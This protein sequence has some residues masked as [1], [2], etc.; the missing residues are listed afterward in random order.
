MSGKWH[1]KPCPVC[2]EGVLRDGHKT[3]VTEYRG[4]EFTSRQSGAYCDKCNDGITYHDQAVEDAWEQF[5][6]RVH[7]DERRELAT[8]R[9][10]LGLTQHDAARI[11]GGGHN[12]FSRYERGEAQPVLGVV[13]LFRLLGRY[14]QLL[15][16]LGVQPRKAIWTCTF[17]IP[18]GVVP[19]VPSAV[20]GGVVPL[21]PSTVVGSYVGIVA[22]AVLTPVLCCERHN[23]TF[24]SAVQGDFSLDEADANVPGLPVVA[25]AYSALLR[26]EF[27]A[28]S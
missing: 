4:R 14:P 11:A 18:G 9:Q 13:N 26:G 16:D 27:D 12:A 17:G 23:W 5:R 1:E 24:D 10:S 7:E 3:E 22:C 20:V 19:L 15:L 8:A 25:G 2:S 28:S 21:V 6:T